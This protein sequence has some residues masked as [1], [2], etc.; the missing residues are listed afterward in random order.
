VVVLIAPRDRGA[1]DG[2]VSTR[3]R[4]VTSST[5]VSLIERLRDGGAGDAW[6]RFV[7]LYTPML[8]RWARR[9]GLQE[10]DA[11]DLTQD[12]LLLLVR[13]LPEFEYDA[14]RSF[15]AWLFTLFA[16]SLLGRLHSHRRSGITR[17]RQEWPVCPQRRQKRSMPK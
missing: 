5:S 7:R 13:K 4:V 11:A 2:N 1:Y 17:N 9:W 6:A 15:R 10:A 8:L 12:V 14:R 3:V 16:P